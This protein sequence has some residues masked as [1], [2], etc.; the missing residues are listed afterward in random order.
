VQ[1]E[2]RPAKTTG[3]A[4]VISFGVLPRDRTHTFVQRSGLRIPNILLDHVPDDLRS[5]SYPRARGVVLTSNTPAVAFVSH[6]ADTVEPFPSA[7]SPSVQVWLT[8]CP[9]AGGHANQ[10]SA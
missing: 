8:L 4:G 10:P 1:G 3:F 9:P 7:V 2:R 5:Q 6:R